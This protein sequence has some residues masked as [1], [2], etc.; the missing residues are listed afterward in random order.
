MDTRG[1]GYRQL[2]KKIE[3]ERESGRKETV[4]KVWR[5]K[6]KALDPKLVPAGS[7]FT[8][9]SA[10]GVSGDS[11][12]SRTALDVSAFRGVLARGRIQGG[13]HPPKTCSTKG[14][15]ERKRETRGREEERERER[16][17][18]REKTKRKQRENK[19]TFFF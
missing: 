7:F 1:Q 10:G 2:K 16:E 8:E 12:I 13:P 15:E 6:N 11:R 19:K 18:E 9:C 3:R 5:E 17:R 14:H 4:G